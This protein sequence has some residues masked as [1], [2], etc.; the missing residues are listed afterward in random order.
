LSIRP[1]VRSDAAAYVAYMN[2]VGGESDYLT[3][4]RDEYGRSVEEVAGMIEAMSAR[5][6]E[7]FCLAFVNGQLVGALML[8]AGHRPRVRHSA[9]LSITVKKDSW[10][11]GIGSALMDY[12]LSWLKSAR[13]ITKVNLRVRDDHVRAIRL[14]EKKGFVSEGITARALRA[15][16]QYYSVRHMGLSIDV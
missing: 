14:Y 3:F 7:L 12:C 5:D 13:T 1:A 15:H 6:N 16:G 10:S 9:E 11:K 8:E 2:E 4:G